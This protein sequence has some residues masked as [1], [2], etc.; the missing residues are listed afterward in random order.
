MASVVSSDVSAAVASFLPAAAEESRGGARDMIEAGVLDG[1]SGASGLHVWPELPSGVI[2][3]KVNTSTA[4]RTA[5]I[6]YWPS[7]SGRC[8]LCMLEPCCQRVASV[9][10][11]G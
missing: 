8:C 3:T 6:P 1:V 5:W 7:Q 11:I 2:S 9:T 4:L 10:V